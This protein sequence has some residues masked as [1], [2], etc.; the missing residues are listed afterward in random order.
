MNDPKGSPKSIRGFASI[1][2][3]SIV[4]SPAKADT[5]CP[6]KNE[7][8][9]KTAPVPQIRDANVEGQFPRSDEALAE[10]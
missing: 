3:R 4:Q 10:P 1:D 9:L 2:R 8:S 5:P 7:P 6:L